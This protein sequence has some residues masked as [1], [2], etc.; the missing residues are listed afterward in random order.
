MLTSIWVLC[1]PSGGERI[2]V[3]AFKEI[4]NEVIR[5]RGSRPEE[6]KRLIVGE[7]LREARQSLSKES[8]EEVREYAIAKL[9]EL[10]VNV[11]DLLEQ[12][13]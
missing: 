13:S 2:Y 4:I 8:F 11:D 3:T 1:M 9:V 10:G 12:S 7:V 6:V 5:E